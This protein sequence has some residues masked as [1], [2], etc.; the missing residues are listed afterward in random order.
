MRSVRAAVAVLVLAAVVPAFG[1]SA[2]PPIVEIDGCVQ[3][4]TACADVR[5]VVKV[6]VDDRKIELAVERA[7]LPGSTASESKLLTELELRGL[8]L[9]GPKEVTARLVAGAHVR[10]R[11][12]LRSGP[13]MLLQSIEPRPEK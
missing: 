6:R 2:R 1:R 4:A 9:H 13:M 12:V 8:T 5:G 10:V 11:G 7:W 3:P